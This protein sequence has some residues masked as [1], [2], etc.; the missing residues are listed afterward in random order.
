MEKF[1]EDYSQR[2]D[3]EKIL[4]N[5]KKVKGLYDRQE[6]S[7]VILRTVTA[8]EL[9]ANYAIRQELELNKNIDSDFVDHL[10]RWANGIQGKFDRLLLPIF[11]GTEFEKDLKKL[12]KIVQ[13]INKERNSIAHSG[14]FKKKSTAEKVIRE[15]KIV[16]N[17]L[18]KKYDSQFELN[19]LIE[20]K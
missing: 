19:L 17:T 8:V 15:S 7:T 13:D 20:K 9:S 18:V 14:L 5:W 6:W 12:K 4:S 1:K 3:I 2:T 10:L 11:K 16:I